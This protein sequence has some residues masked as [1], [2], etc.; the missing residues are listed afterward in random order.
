MSS[1]TYAYAYGICIQDISK[2]SKDICIQG[3]R[4][5]TFRKLAMVLKKDYNSSWGLQHCSVTPDKSTMIIWNMYVLAL[6]K[7]TDRGA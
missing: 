5:R 4:K 6:K 7:K 2:T 3:T 1:K